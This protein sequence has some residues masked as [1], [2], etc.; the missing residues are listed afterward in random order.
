MLRIKMNRRNSVLTYNELAGSKNGTHSISDEEKTIRISTTETVNTFHYPAVHFIREDCSIKFRDSRRI[1]GGSVG[2]YVDTDVFPQVRAYIDSVETLT[3]V[4][5]SPGDVPR[6]FLKIKLTAP[7]NNA[8]CRD[9]D[10]DEVMRS[11]ETFSTATPN[12]KRCVGDH[13]LY[14]WFLYE[15]RSVRNGEYQFS[16]A[17][18]LNNRQR[19]TIYSEEF[20]SGSMTINCYVPIDSLN[21]DIIDTLVWEPSGSE[22]EARNVLEQG[23][24]SEI[25]LDDCRFYDRTQ[26]GASGRIYVNLRPGTRLCLE[27]GNLR[28][29]VP[30]AED[31]AT[32]LYME[33]ALDAFANARAEE[34]VNKIIDYEKMKFIPCFLDGD[35]TRLY[36]TMTYNIRLRNRVLNEE[37]KTE[38]EQYWFSAPENAN[39]DQRYRS[40]LVSALGFDDADVYYQKEKVKNTFLRLSFYNSNDRRTQQLLY[41]AKIYLDSGKL[42][43]KFIKNAEHYDW[44][45]E[46]VDHRFTADTEDNMYLEFTCSNSLDTGNTSEGFYLYMFP[47]NL[48]DNERAVIYMKAELS[49]S[50]YGYTVPLVLPSK[51]NSEGVRVEDS[52]GTNYICKETVNGKEVF[53]PDMEKLRE[54]TFVPIRI[55][56]G[57]DNRYYW[58]FDIDFEADGNNF[59]TTLYEPRM[60]GTSLEGVDAPRQRVRNRETDLEQWLK[61]DEEISPSTD[62]AG[63][64]QGGGSQGGG[65]GQEGGGQ[66]GGGICSS[67]I[68]P[69]AQDFPICSDCQSEGLPCNG[70]CS[71]DV[72]P[73]SPECISETLPCTSDCLGE[74]QPCSHDCPGE[75]Q[76]CVPDCSDYVDPICECDSIDE[77]DC[78]EEGFCP[79]YEPP[80]D[81]I[82][83]N[84]VPFV[85]MEQE[86]NSGDIPMS[87]EFIQVGE[88][89]ANLTV[90][91]VQEGGEGNIPIHVDFEQVLDEE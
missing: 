48:N 29:S 54:D 86:S 11:P 40:D 38:D 74:I 87:V 35:K 26:N 1:V 73:C 60:N 24:Y 90:E 81:Y 67:E 49:N 85:S 70:D 10:I 52:L 79:N 9:Y 83:R 69:C 84:V 2:E 88:V 65:G 27:S 6:T 12:A 57:S 43:G 46:I 72:E 82:Q 25:L 31:F 63:G 59:G 22:R 5:K 28:V 41:S 77:S 34:S 33:D 66:D 19:M 78:T 44:A 4:K 15:I 55:F 58:A 23:K 53:S 51:V 32:N 8:T 68:L 47:S 56:K 21:N 45:E 7:H 20:A 13:F 80:I 18:N 75:E 64:N 89:P 91:L 36:E 50:K 76:I 37:W 71:V 3:G 42:F 39:F 30:I 61:S 16:N 62:G 17:L 14:E